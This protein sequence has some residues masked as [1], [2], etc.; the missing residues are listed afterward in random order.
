LTLMTVLW[1]TSTVFG[2]PRPS[3]VAPSPVAQD[4]VVY[5]MGGYPGQQTVAIRAGGT[6][7]VTMSHIL[8]SSR[9]SSYIPSPVLHDGHLYW[10]SDQGIAN[11]L[12]AKTGKSVYRERLPRATNAGSGKPYYASIVLNGGRLYAVSRTG[13]T[14]VL[15]TKPTFEVLAHNPLASDKSDFNVSP[16]IS[17]GK[18]LLRSNRFLYCIAAE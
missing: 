12:E 16:A 4:G 1:A 2:Q 3:V 7:N 18:I 11:C 5:V 6:G 8:W 17:N 9:D 14:Y 13:G 10:V 15:P